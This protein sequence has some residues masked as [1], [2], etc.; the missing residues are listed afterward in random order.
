MYLPV[1]GYLARRGRCGTINELELVG[2][3][4]RPIPSWLSYPD[5]RTGDC[6]WQ[7]EEEEEEEDEEGEEEVRARTHVFLF[8]FV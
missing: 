4:V 8:Y 7:E 2:L 1:I 6:G 3:C 5:G